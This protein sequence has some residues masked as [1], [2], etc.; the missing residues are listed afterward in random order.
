MSDVLAML[1]SGGATGLIGTLF[2]GGLAIFKK[3]QINK[4]ALAM[5]KIDLEELTLE[6]ELG[7]QQT[8][9]QLEVASE[10]SQA[11]AMEASYVNER[12]FA[13]KGI[14]YTPAQA[15][16]IVF[17][18]VI[19]G[20]MRPAITVF[21]LQ[22][23]WTMYMT[24]Y[25]GIDTE[26]AIAHSVIYMATTVTLWWFGSPPDRQAHGSDKVTKSALRI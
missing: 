19:R 1:L 14:E 21:L 12:T 2:S 25:G 3:N 20:L 16:A 10:E 7:R 5:R 23:L 6:A 24:K 26:I 4:Q 11:R 17:I 18:D 13:S 22:M 8:A 9:L 15:W